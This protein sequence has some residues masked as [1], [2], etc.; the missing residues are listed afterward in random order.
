MGLHKMLKAAVR[1]ICQYARERM[2]ET[3]QVI[4]TGG[5]AKNVMRYNNM[6]QML[7]KPDLVMQGLYTIK[8]QRKA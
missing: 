7:H 1:D 3:T 5:W 2:G 4:V 6:P 8:M